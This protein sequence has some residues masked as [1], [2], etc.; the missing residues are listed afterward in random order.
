MNERFTGWAVVKFVK[1]VKLADMDLRLQ[2][3][4][5]VL[6]F[7]QYS[8]ETGFLAID[9]VFRLGCASFLPDRTLL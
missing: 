8:A 5:N 1:W 4:I 7:R 6:L 2:S 9:R 3:V